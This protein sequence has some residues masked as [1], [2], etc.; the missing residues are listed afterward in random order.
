MATRKRPSA[1][2]GARIL[3]GL[4]KR[5]NHHYQKSVCAWRGAL[6][7]ALKCGKALNKARYY[8]W[9]RGVWKKWL[10]DHFDASYETAKVYMRIAKKWEDPRL[11]EARETGIELKSI[12][13]VLDILEGNRATSADMDLPDDEESQEPTKAMLLDSMRDEVRTKF[14]HMLH[15]LCMEE[16]QFMDANWDDYEDQFKDQLSDLTS[17]ALGFDINEYILQSKKPKR[18]W[19]P[20]GFFPRVPNYVVKFDMNTMERQRR[21]DRDKDLRERVNKKIHDAL[22]GES[23]RR[24]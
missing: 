12:K 16:L 6:K 3:P 1:L 22:N 11:K 20:K 10:E 23:R 2:D 4:A 14:A 5:A 21:V 9:K 15:A 7:H 19:E 13:S 8:N 17:A 24:A 18:K